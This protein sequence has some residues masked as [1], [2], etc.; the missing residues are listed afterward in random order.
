MTA[1]NKAI[2]AFLTSIVALLTGF[3]VDLGQWSSTETIGAVATL[4]GAA[5]V[6]FVPNKT[7]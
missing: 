5:L 7:S 6:Y 1:Y 3:G 2:A 4:V